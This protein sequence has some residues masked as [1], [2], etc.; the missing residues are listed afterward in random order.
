[1]FDHILNSRY[2]SCAIEI[3]TQVP[4]IHG[5]K[6]R[7][8]LVRSVLTHDR[9]IETFGPSGCYNGVL[10]I[11][12]EGFMP[13]LERVNLAERYDL[14]IM[15]TKGL[16]VTAARRLIDKV[17]GEN[18]IPC[19]VLHDFDKSGFSIL[20]TLGRDTARYKYENAVE[21]APAATGVLPLEYMLS[22]IRDSAAD[23]KRRDAMAMAAA[24]YLH[25]RLTAI[26]AKLNPAVPEQSPRQ[27]LIEF[28]L[29][30]QDHARD[31]E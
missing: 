22:V 24:P 19:F 5:R 9:A 20:G 4:A 21:F 23:N 15:S 28:V 30:T 17:C 25:P 8:R 31:Q 1:V 27:L 29:P 18:D 14:G 10:F 16:S 6:P 12:K 11:E 26:D 2:R 7:R 13:L 3:L